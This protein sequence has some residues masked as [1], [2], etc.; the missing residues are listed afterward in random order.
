MSNKKAI[1]DLIGDPRQVDRELGSFRQTARILSSDHPRL[2]DEYPR[3]WIAAYE[4]KVRVAGRTLNSVLS[5][6]E[7]QGLPKQRV[8]IRYIDKNQ[9][10]MIL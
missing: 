4:G 7:K 9:R 10:T 8:I 2:I 3:Q 5:Q 1:L 6:V